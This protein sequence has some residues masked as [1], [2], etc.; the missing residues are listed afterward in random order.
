MGEA[1]DR[2]EARQQARMAEVLADFEHTGNMSQTCRNCAIARSTVDGWRRYP[3][4]VE[5]WRVAAAQHET[6]RMQRLA[7][8]IRNLPKMDGDAEQLFLDTIAATADLPLAANAVGI[9][10][11]TILSLRW[12]DAAFAAAWDRAIAASYSRLEAQMLDECINGIG[13]MPDNGRT[14]AADTTRTR[15]L[16]NGARKA[17]AREAAAS[18]EAERDRHEALA[19]KWIADL[20]A[21]IARSLAER[22][23]AA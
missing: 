12:R 23:A 18:D 6:L 22:G 5:K 17:G 20:R 10:L 7:A 14:R 15:M 9:P 8:G 11:G 3:D 1:K 19:A 2:K 4:Y 16:A 13:P 21:A